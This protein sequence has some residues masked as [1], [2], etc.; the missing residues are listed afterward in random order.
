MTYK[1]L[2]ENF[3]L[4]STFVKYKGLEDKFVELCEDEQGR[5]IRYVFKDGAPKNNRCLSWYDKLQPAALKRNGHDVEE[6]SKHLSKVGDIFYLGQMTCSGYDKEGHEHCEPG[7][8]SEKCR[9]NIAS[10]KYWTP[11]EPVKCACW[12]LDALTGIDDYRLKITFGDLKMLFELVKEKENKK[13]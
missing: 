4:F 9:K 3:T 1:E 6:W 8:P 5:Y 12:I 13:L 10:L 7:C 2:Q 11:E